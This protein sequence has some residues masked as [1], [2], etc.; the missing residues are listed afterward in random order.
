MIF[1]ITQELLKEIKS[2]PANLPACP[3]CNEPAEYKE[4]VSKWDG[5]PEDRMEEC[6]PRYEQPQPFDVGTVTCSAN[7]SCP[8]LTEF[9]LLDWISMCWIAKENW[10]KL[11]E[12]DTGWAKTK[13]RGV[14]VEVKEP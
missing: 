9:W 14:E 2:N 13:I 5:W 1:N 4:G 10:T 12:A 8:L 11:L 6:I 3:I 7:G